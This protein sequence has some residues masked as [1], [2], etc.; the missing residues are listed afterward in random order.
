MHEIH[1]HELQ[2]YRGGHMRRRHPCFVCAAMTRRTVPVDG[3]RLVL[4]SR[5]KSPT[6]E[7]RLLAAIFGTETLPA[8]ERRLARERKDGARE[9]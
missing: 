8:L 4:C 5:C 1:W 7:Q 9:D 6:P 2:P 3:G